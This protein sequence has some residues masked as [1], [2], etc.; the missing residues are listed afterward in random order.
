M[1]DRLTFVSPKLCPWLFQVS[2]IWCLKEHN[3]AWLESVAMTSWGWARVYM[4]KVSQNESYDSFGSQKPYLQ[5]AVLQVKG[6]PSSSRAHFW[7]PWIIFRIYFSF[8]GYLNSNC[9]RS[10]LRIL[11]CM[12]KYFKFEQ[13]LRHITLTSS[14]LI[15][16]LKQECLLCKMSTAF[17]MVSGN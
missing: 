16:W 12:Y 4:E 8:H 6:L 3:R 7:S 13:E 1:L 9:C 5:F 15:R 14:H 17:K 11:P 10:N 2:Q